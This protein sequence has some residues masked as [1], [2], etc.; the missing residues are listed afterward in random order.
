MLQNMKGIVENFLIQLPAVPIIVIHRKRLGIRVVP[1]VSR[2]YSDS[3]IREGAT[4]KGSNGY[5]YR[6]LARKLGHCP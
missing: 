6:D 1:L 2:F 3:F 5:T 4:S